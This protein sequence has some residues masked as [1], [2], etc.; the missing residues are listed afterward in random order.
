[1]SRLEALTS[2]RVA[3]AARTIS[4]PATIAARAQFTTPTRIGE[5]PSS[6]APRSLS[7]KALVWRPN[8]VN[9]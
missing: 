9:R 5:I 7:A 1:M 8:R 2:R 3:G 6:T 4:R